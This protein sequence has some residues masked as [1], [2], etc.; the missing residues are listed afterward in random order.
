MNKTSL[1]AFFLV[2]S[3]IW[4]ATN[5][6]LLLGQTIPIPAAEMKKVH[7]GDIDIAYKMFG[8]GDPIILING[9]SAPL[10]FW[11]SNFL[12]KLASNHTV[13]AF[14]NRGIGNTTS[15]NKNFTISQF[16]NDTSGLM[17]ALKI[18]KADV[19]GW[20]M[21]SF[22]AQELTLA[23]PEKVGKL[24]LYGSSCGGS[25]SKPP[26]PEVAKIFGNMSINEMEKLQKLEPFLFSK[27]WRVQN[28]NYLQSLPRVTE[29][30]PNET[31]IEQ[32]KA[33]FNWKGDCGQISSINKP[34]LVIV[35]TQDAFTVP[36]N[37]LIMTEKIPAAWLV[38]I[39]GGHAMMF[40][41]PEVFSNL[42]LTFLKS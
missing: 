14:D 31:L 8:K 22:I 38:Q 32:E 3:F 6:N 27:E 36:E 35:G 18:K 24:I 28:P 33:I 15:G 2:I 16:A 12:N 34:T 1:L 41:Q 25:E 5:N 11:E 40:E 37:S 20:S 4:S 29:I 9:Y 21:G 7:V 26:K 42:I 23:H 17:D 30:I 13:I 19:M 39:R 10:E